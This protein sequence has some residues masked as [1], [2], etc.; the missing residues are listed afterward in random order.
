MNSQRAL[1]HIP[2]SL[3]QENNEVSNFLHSEGKQGENAKI[4]KEEVVTPNNLL[5]RQF[6]HIKASDEI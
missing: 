1:L 6:Y 2:P 4:E 5:K 3:R